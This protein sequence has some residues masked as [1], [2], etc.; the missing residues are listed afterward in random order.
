MASVLLFGQ[1]C[2]TAL[3]Y[4]DKQGPQIG[5]TSTRR[6]DLFT[7]RSAD[8]GTNQTRAASCRPFSKLLALP[9]VAISALAVT[10]PIPGSCRYA[11]ETLPMA[12]LNLLV[13]CGDDI[14][15]KVRHVVL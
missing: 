3:A 7:P 2:N 4:M 9:M 8:A 15:L 5:I 6:Q 12:L 10:G 14:R 11:G 13:E 1:N